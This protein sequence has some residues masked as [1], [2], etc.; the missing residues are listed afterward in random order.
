M[1]KKLYRMIVLLRYLTKIYK[2]NMN[3]NKL[4]LKIAEGDKIDPVDKGTILRKTININNEL[5]VISTTLNEAY[6]EIY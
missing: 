5:K 6:K 2:I 4:S 1:I 3:L